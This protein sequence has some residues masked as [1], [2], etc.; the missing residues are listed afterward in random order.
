M[1][2]T[3]IGATYL[4]VE[5]WENHGR[6]WRDGQSPFSRSKTS[7]DIRTVF[8]NK[9]NVSSQIFDPELSISGSKGQ[10]QKCDFRL[11]VDGHRTRSLD[12]CILLPVFYASW[13]P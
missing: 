12:G 1:F 2:F 10:V 13:Q 4:T 8:R 5:T 3:K 11:R 9:A 7:L 6:G